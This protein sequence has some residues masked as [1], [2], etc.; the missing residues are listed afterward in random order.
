MV[1]TALPESYAYFLKQPVYRADFCFS[2]PEFRAV[3]GDEPDRKILIIDDM[4]LH[5]LYPEVSFRLNKYYSSHLL[6]TF[7]T[8]R[9]FRYTSY[10]KNEDQPVKLFL[11]NS[12]EMAGIFS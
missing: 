3:G 7:W 6:S 8:G 11:L 1:I 12:S 10:G 2:C 4:A 5:D 9:P